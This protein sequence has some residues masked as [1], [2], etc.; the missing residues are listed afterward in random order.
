MEMLSDY[1][2]LAS[3]L[4]LTALEIVLGVDNVIFIAL[5]T[6][7]LDRKAAKKAR[8][9]GLTLA[10]VMRVGF[11]LTL[12]W[13]MGMTKPV[14]TLMGHGFSGRD[15]LMFAGGLFLIYKAVGSMHEEMTHEQ[16]KELKGS[17]KRFAMTILQIVVID[18]VFSF[19]S[20]LTAVGLTQNVP[21]IVAA[22]VIAMVVMMFSSGMIADFIKR[23]PTIK[24]L[25]L[26]FILMIGVLLVAEGFG[27][28]IPRGYIYFSM[29]FSLMVESLNLIT[30]K[31]KSRG[32]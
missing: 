11:L 30:A 18:I 12:A 10:M 1:Q 16:A 29:F 25:A 13:I 32:R 24:M 6:Q 4:T 20:V 3:F 26:A 15:L 5:L 19:D 9:I 21:V 17:K 28:H 22:M 31:K 14:L 27:F 2:L 8:M 23:F 7:H